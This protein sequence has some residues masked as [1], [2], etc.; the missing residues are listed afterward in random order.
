YQRQTIQFS[1]R[2]PALFMQSSPVVGLARDLAL[3]GLDWVTPLKRA[4]VHHAA[5]MN[6]MEGAGG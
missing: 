4:F 1:D 3:S 6:A 5:G 2:L